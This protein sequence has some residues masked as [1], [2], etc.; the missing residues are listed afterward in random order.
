MGGSSGTSQKTN[1][2]PWIAQ[3]P[4]MLQGFQSAYDLYGQPIS[5]ETMGG[6]QNW[7]NRAQAGSP[8]TRAAQDFTQNAL[9]G[10]N[11]AIISSFKPQLDSM[12]EAGGRAGGTARSE[13]FGRGFANAALPYA[14][15]APQL[16]NMDYYDIGQGIEAS[17]APY[18]EELRRLAAYMGIVGQQGGDTSTTSGGKG[19]NPAIQGIGA[20]GQLAGGIGSMYGS[21]SS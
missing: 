19:A 12:F 9:T 3:Q 16:A 6:Y 11:N 5:P 10:N 13:A 21:M 20:L 18:N 2:A 8:L 4:Y 17:N 14:Q 15:I 1:N 7:Y